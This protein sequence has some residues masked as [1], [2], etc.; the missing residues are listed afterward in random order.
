MSLLLISSSSLNLYLSGIAVG[1]IYFD[2]ILEL[3]VLDSLF[4]RKTNSNI[5]PPIHKEIYWK[6]YETIGCEKNWN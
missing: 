3:R 1:F 2:N 4:F 5:I 6:Q